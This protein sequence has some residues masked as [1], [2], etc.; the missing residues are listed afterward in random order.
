VSRVVILP[1]VTPEVGINRLRV[2]GLWA[3]SKRGGLKVCRDAA[4][5]SVKVRAL[6]GVVIDAEPVV[7]VYDVEAV[8]V[9]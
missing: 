4:L 1:L 2:F 6:S 5:P 7:C 9:H 3:T 8:V